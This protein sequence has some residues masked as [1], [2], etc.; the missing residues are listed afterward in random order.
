MTSE[1]RTRRIHEI[2][3][4]TDDRAELAERIVALEELAITEY[5]LL[6]RAYWQPAGFLTHGGIKSS[7]MAEVYETMRNLGIK[8]GE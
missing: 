4:S 1:Q 8:V 6:D 3:Y 5:K 2:T 7:G